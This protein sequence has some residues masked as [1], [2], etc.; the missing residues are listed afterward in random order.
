[1]GDS[2]KPGRTVIASVMAALD[3]RPVMP[4]TSHVLIRRKKPVPIFAVAIDTP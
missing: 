2:S 1:M 3:G 4:M